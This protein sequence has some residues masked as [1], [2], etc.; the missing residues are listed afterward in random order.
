MALEAK[1]HIVFAVLAV[2]V[3]A[4]PAVIAFLVQSWAG[5]LATLTARAPGTITR[6]S[7]P[8]KDKKCERRTVGGQT[9]YECWTV[10]SA[11]CSTSR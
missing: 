7:E 5:E 4:C 10:Y 8:R 3:G 9:S 1:H 11:N 2:L 6:I